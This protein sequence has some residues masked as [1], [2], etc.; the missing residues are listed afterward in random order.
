MLRRAVIHLTNPLMLRLPALIALFLILAGGSS[1]ILGKT[2]DEDSLRDN[3]MFIAYRQFSEGG[4]A[5]K[6]TVFAGD[7][8][9]FFL[10]NE[11]EQFNVQILYMNQNGTADVVKTSD[12]RQ[13]NPPRTP[14]TAEDGCEWKQ[15]L[16]F[17]IPD[18]W[19]SGWYRL[20][21]TADF[22]KSQR[23]V[24]FIVAEKVPS[25]DALFVFDTQ[26]AQAYNVY[27]GGSFYGTFDE[28]GA[29]SYDKPK[30]AL[31]FRRPV[32]RSHTYAAQ[33][34]AITDPIWIPHEGEA[35]RLWLDARYSVAYVSNDALETISAAYLQK[36]PMIV[37][38]GTQE[39]WSNKQV[40]L[41]K[42]YVLE[43]GNLFVAA[44]EFPYGAVR[45]DSDDVFRFFYEVESD[46]VFRSDPSE[47]ATVRA[48]LSD[49]EDFF[50]VSLESGK[51]LAQDH[52]YEPLIIVDSNHWALTD[53]GFSNGDSMAGVR[54]Y[55]PGA[56]LEQQLNGK[57]R[58]VSS[59]L[60]RESVEVLAI[61]PYP[62]HNVSMTESALDL[63]LDGVLNHISPEIPEATFAIVALVQQG[64]GQIFL[65]PPSL[66]QSGE[67]GYDSRSEI[68]VS[69]VIA[70]F[71]Q[72]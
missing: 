26:T 15:T 45:F 19:P 4:Y 56:W 8:I 28:T 13:G 6:R 49:P 46:P 54:G 69:N 2:S 51:G 31:S 40:E 27:A 21:F 63:A 33:Q 29:W 58:I 25:A 18:G 71:T 61:A 38:A 52:G 67:P 30:D 17:T 10:A 41:I 35:F 36:Y 59:T 5:D 11:K 16:K 24:D 66:T 39:Y 60:A 55:I 65:A 64:A 42:S 12:V 7:D 34:D 62:P 48:A 3:L 53:S 68:V 14:C 20:A 22:A 43:G 9:T 72:N 44:S 1:L 37:I 23:Y 70:R 32:V 57:Y 47:V 50:G